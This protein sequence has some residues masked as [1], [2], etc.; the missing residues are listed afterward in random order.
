GTITAALEH[1]KPLLVMPRLKKFG[2][3]VNDHQV[4][5][6][7]RFEQAGLL[8][9]AY[10]ADEFAACL[11]KLKTFV[12]KKRECAT[13]AVVERISRFLQEIKAHT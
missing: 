1:N 8:L 7:Q 13:D 2:E 4:G 3:V 5:I 10:N 6:A 12:P 9:A 11:T